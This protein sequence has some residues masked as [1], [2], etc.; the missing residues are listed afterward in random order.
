MMQKKKR[1]RISLM[2][3]ERNNKGSKLK[4]EIQVINIKIIGKANKIYG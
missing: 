1:N 2:K 4:Q 3:V